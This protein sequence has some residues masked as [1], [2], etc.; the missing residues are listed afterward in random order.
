MLHS[1]RKQ[2]CKHIGLYLAIKV[3]ISFENYKY[4]DCNFGIQ[5]KELPL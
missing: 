1:D 2:L 5:E 3:K 4:L